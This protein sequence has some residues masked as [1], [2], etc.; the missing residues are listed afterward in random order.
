MALEELMLSKTT[1][2][3]SQELFCIM[4]VINFEGIS[5]KVQDSITILKREEN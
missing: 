2:P 4:I 3:G 5:N 1:R